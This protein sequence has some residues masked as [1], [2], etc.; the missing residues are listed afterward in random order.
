[1]SDRPRIFEDMA[2]MAGGALSVLT[3][4]RAE[5]EALVRARVEDVLR[6]LDVVRREE[7]DAAL[8]MA[9]RARAGQE[10]AESR[11]AA[12]E[13]RLDSLESRDAPIGGGEPGMIT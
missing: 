4:M 12:I 3:G 6:R 8:E 7:M 9:A 10:E 13:S 11:L 1:M 5:V 2:G